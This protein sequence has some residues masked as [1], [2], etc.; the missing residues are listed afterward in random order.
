MRIWP[1]R[2]STRPGAAAIHFWDGVSGGVTATGSG[3]L[4]LVVGAV[5]F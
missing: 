4:T 1:V 3:R 5:G 2:G